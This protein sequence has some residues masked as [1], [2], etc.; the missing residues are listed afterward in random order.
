MSEDNTHRAAVAA[1]L[2]RTPA[3][4]KALLA[5]FEQAFAALWQRT[6]LTL[7]DVTMT[8]IVDRV[9]HVAEEQ[10][11]ALA[12]LELEEAGVR[13]RE[14][15]PPA[16]ASP[17]RLAE[18]IEFVLVEFLT[19]LGNLTA[20]ILTPALHAELSKPYAPNDVDEDPKS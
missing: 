6:R 13:W 17:D 2:G 16:G 11:P 7:G 9:L 12:S 19:V 5:A 8:A 10:F 15:S 4:P 1:W 20:E 18:G 14:P 3:E